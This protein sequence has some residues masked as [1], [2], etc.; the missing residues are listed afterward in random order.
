MRFL[1]AV[2]ADRRAT[3]AATPGE[4]AAIDSFNDRIGAAGHRIMAAGVAAP[5]AAYVVDNRS[6]LA[7]ITEG[8]VVDA[9]DFMAGFWIIEAPNDEV[10]R[11]L[12]TDASAAC[13]RRIEVR[14]F[15]R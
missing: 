10:A 2:M 13:N 8:P 4:A 1:F 6:G 3:V 12:A 11:S 15:L 7:T 9:D 14:P 5:D